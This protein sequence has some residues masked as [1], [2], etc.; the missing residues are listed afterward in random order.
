MCCT[1]HSFSRKKMD[2]EGCNMPDELYYRDLMWLKT[3]PDGYVR[4]GL[5][6]FGQKTVGKIVLIRLRHEGKTVEQDEVFGRFHGSRIWFGP[7]K[8][9]VT[10][11]IVEVNHSV[12][13]DPSLTNRDPYGKG[14]L[15]RV[16]A[17]NLEEQLETLSHGK[18]QVSDLVKN[19]IL[20]RKQKPAFFW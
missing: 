13:N 19:L 2:V 20:E 1:R 6:D 10:G 18:K 16:N 17:S 14:W 4:V 15:I 5:T 7:F 9:P 3:E 11:T 8:A 12:M